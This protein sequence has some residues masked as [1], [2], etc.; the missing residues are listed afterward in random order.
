ML[1][2]FI[3]IKW[4]QQIAANL[5]L[6]MVKKE[7]VPWHGILKQH[8]CSRLILSTTG[9]LCFNLISYTNAAREKNK[10]ACWTN[11]AFKLNYACWALF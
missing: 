8:A 4:K 10:T 11:T 6:T 3:D 5:S 1:A 7:I 9:L 2:A